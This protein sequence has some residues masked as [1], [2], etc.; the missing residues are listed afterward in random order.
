MARQLTPFEECKK[1]IEELKVR[2]ARCLKELQEINNL[3]KDIILMLANPQMY[4]K[5]KGENNGN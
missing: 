5:L 2:K 1:A 4:D 3:E